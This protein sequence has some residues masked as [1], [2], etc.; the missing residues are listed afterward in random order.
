MFP[1]INLTRFVKQNFNKF[2]DQIL[3]C[4]VNVLEYE[5]PFVLKRKRDLYCWSLVFFRLESPTRSLVM[6]A[7]KGVEIN[8]EAG[9]MEATCRTEL[10][11]ESKDGEVRGEKGRSSQSY[12]SSRPTLP[13]T[14]WPWSWILWHIKKRSQAGFISQQ[15]IEQHDYKPNPQSIKVMIISKMQR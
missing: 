12:S 7:P 8:A 9:N 4:S 13:L 14:G 3:E 2:S 1:V 11:L 15:L 5:L 10:R 6:E